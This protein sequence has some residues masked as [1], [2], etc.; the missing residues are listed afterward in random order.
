[1]S[2]KA[3]IFVLVVSLILSILSTVVVKAGSGLRIIDS[4][5]QAEFPT[6]L[7]FNLK[8][9]SDVSVT[10]VRLHYIVEHEGYAQV[11]SEVYVEL[12]PALTIDV[13]WSWDMRRTGG[14]PPGSS[15]EYWW[16][17]YDADG[18]QFKTTPVRVQ[19]DDNRYP[20]RSLSEGKVTI[21]WYDGGESFA[22][23]LMLTAQQAISRLSE[24]TG[25]RLEKPVVIYIYADSRDLQGALIYPQEWTGGVTFQ[26]YGTIAIGISPEDITWGKRATVHELTHLVIHQATFNPYNDLPTWLDEGLAMYSEGALEAPLRS[27]LNRAIAENELISVRGLSSPFSAFPEKSYLSYAQSYSLVEFLIT[28]YGQARMLELLNIF[29]QGSTGDEALLKVYDFNMDGL[30][31]LWRAYVAGRRQITE[32]SIAGVYMELALGGGRWR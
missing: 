30:D 28:N 10:D 13:G 31:S 12:V 15:L 19:F 32:V 7:S 1:M 9:E 25:A 5:A 11:T 22:N 26:R 2:K 23:E 6:E 14:L 29:R 18:I 17:V 8:A 3:G 27:L 16:T 21:H 4:S 24:D 20:W